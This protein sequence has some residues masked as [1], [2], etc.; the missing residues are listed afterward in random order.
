MT[1]PF[2]E[3]VSLLGKLSDEELKKLKQRITA[4][5]A[6]GGAAA[7]GKVAEGDD[8]HTLVLQSISDV[9]SDRGLGAVSVA[10]MRRSSVF[11]DT[12][13]EKVGNIEKPMRLGTYNTIARR[14]IVLLGVQ[15]LHRYLEEGIPVR[16]D[17]DKKYLVRAQEPVTWRH[18]MIYIDLMPYALDKAFPGYL[19]TQ[20][21][22]F[23][24]KGH[25]GRREG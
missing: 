5:Q 11:S 10:Q 3:V 21:M 14:G 12:F 18:L 17:S 25:I 23:L 8:I 7:E 19:G 1:V 9:L 15:C 22:N 6:L 24:L 16:W 4:L 13:R 2:D 20:L